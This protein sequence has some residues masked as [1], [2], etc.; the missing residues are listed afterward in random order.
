MAESSEFQYMMLSRLKADCEY[1][2]GR[3]GHGSER[4]L[5]TQNVETHIQLMK[6]RWNALP[7]EGKPLWLNMQDILDYESVMLYIKAKKIYVPDP[8][9]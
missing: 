4:A 2:I 8:A 3:Y 5:Y 7:D 6:D 9:I 1:Y